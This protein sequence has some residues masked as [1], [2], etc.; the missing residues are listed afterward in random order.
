M[1][2][3]KAGDGATATLLAFA[4]LSR[5]NTWVKGLGRFTVPLL[6]LPWRGVF[7]TNWDTLLER[8]RPQV[9][10]RAYYRLEGSWA[11]YQGGGR[12]RGGYGAG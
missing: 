3:L 11:S 5:H 6:Q 10:D 8:T 12:F 2:A 9:L 4:A 7:T 1:T